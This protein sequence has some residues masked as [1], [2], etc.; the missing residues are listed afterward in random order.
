MNV[1]LNIST[2]VLLAGQGFLIRHR[3]QFTT[4]WTNDGIFTSNNPLIT[5]LTEG[6]CY[7]FELTFLSS[8]SPLVDCDPITFVICLPEEQPCATLNYTYEPKGNTYSIV[9]NFFLPSPAVL[10]CGGYN[11]YYQKITSPQIPLSFVHYSTLPNFINIPVPFPDDWIFYLYAV[12]CE[13]NEQLCDTLIAEYEAPPCTAAV[14]NSTTL[15]F[16]GGNYVLTFNIS[17]STPTTNTFYVAYNQCQIVNSGNPDGGNVS[18]NSTGN[19]P[20]VFT[21]NVNPN[22][23]VN[24]TITY[25]GTI[26]DNCGISHNFDVSLTD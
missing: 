12:D 6:T 25:C 22:L 11:L 18:K 21:I 13:G 8:V 14:L 3:V 2:P 24:N 1:T 23:N 20:E 5:G 7:E 17:Q 26:T 4:M 10:P 16:I 19:N 15:Q 9:I